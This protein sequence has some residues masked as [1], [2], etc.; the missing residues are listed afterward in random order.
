M[1]EEVRFER[2]R[3]ITRQPVERIAYARRPG[4]GSA[5]TAKRSFRFPSGEDFP[6][7]LQNDT[8]RSLSPTALM[9]QL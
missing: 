1:L 2:M 3:R 9:R 6:H 8:D 7:P 5:Q 4:Q